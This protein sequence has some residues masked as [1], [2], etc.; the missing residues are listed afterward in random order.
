[1]KKLSKPR[2]RLLEA[3]LT[4]GGRLKATQLT[5]PDRGL[6][7]CMQRDG[8]VEWICPDNQSRQTCI[9]QTACITAAGR[10]ALSVNERVA[11]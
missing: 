3:L 9:G 8:L 6:A 1:M 4:Y 10:A 11:S 7:T 2:R 5:V